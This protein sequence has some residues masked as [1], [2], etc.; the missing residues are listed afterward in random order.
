[1][2]LATTLAKTA[3]HE[4]VLA[5]FDLMLGSLD[6][7]L[8]VVTDRTL[9]GVVQHID[10][11]DLTLLKRSLTRQPSGLFVLPHPAAMEEAARL[12]PDALRRVLALLK[13]AFP[14]VVVDTSKALQ[15]SDFVAFEAADLILVA[16]QLDPACLQNTARLLRLFR[17][18]DGLA[19]RVRLV[20]NRIG[21]HASEVALKAAEEALEM[22]ISW[23]IP[24]ATKAVNA[25]R[26]KG[27]PV[28][29]VAPGSRVHQSFL[30][31]ARALRPP[32][33][34]DPVKPRRGLFAALF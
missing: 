15:S 12:D 8:D 32:T 24:N 26:A 7:C 9:Q 18:F 30:E 34:A 23:Q 10:R 19:G 31:I 20:V 5:D 6:A 27:V 11:L 4:V 28:D 25:A 22:P 1:M 14:A 21:S 16:V 29:E 33:N 3:G 2:N 13:S 17:Q